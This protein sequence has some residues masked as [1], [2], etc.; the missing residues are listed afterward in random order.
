M[1]PLPPRQLSLPELTKRYFELQR[2]FDE[3]R[4]MVMLL[5]RELQEDIQELKEEER[6]SQV[7]VSFRP[8]E[9]RYRGKLQSIPAWAIVVIVVAV[10]CTVV[11]TCAEQPQKGSSGVSTLESLIS[12]RLGR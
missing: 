1:A 6:T 12:S 7:E 5:V 4:V 2:E 8:K 11:A 3:H 9:G 10:C